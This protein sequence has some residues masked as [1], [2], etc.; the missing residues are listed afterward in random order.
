MIKETINSLYPSGSYKYDIM[1]KRK[2]FADS[3]AMILK[4]NA[5]ISSKWSSRELSNT[6]LIHLL[7]VVGT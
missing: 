7:V 1:V 3:V 5:F 2:I 4:I 6:S